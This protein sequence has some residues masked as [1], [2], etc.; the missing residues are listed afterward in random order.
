MIG[1]FFGWDIIFFIGII[2][3]FYLLFAGN[4][5]Y[6]IHGMLMLI[7]CALMGILYVLKKR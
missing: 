2:L 5:L 3:T 4:E 7:M 1:K 6:A